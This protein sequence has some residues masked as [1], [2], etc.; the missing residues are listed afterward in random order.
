LF[1]DYHMLLALERYF[2]IPLEDEATP[3]EANGKEK[4]TMLELKPKPIEHKQKT[5][6]IPYIKLNSWALT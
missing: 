2:G 3:N 5:V 4:E 1:L 6:D